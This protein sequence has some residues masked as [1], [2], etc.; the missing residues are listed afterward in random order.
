[1]RT[2]HAAQIASFRCWR[3]LVMAIEAMPDS[4]RKFYELDK[5]VELKGFPVLRL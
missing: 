2:P 4:D 5:I 1:M 3:N